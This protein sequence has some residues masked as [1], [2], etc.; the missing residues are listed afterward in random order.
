MTRDW[1]ETSESGAG[2]R[3]PGSSSRLSS[4]RSCR[5]RHRSLT[6]W[7]LWGMLCGRMPRADKGEPGGGAEGSAA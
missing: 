5:R 7:A 6:G 4:L 1:G 3:L 2:S